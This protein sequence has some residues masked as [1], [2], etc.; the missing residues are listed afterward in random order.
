VVELGKPDAVVRKYLARMV[1]KD[2]EFLRRGG[3]APPRARTESVMPAEIV[4]T[5]PNIDFRHGNKSAEILG[6]AAFDE[7]GAPLQ[8]LEPKSRV[9]LRVSVRARQ[10]LD[11]PNVGFMLRN[12]LG[13]DFAGTNTVREGVTLPPM[14]A[15][16][17]YTVDFELDLPEL[18]PG[19]F[20]FSPAIA[21]GSLNSYEMC[22]WIDN[23]L[24]LQMAH[25]Q[26][27]IYGYIHLPCRV[28]VNTPLRARQA[29]ESSL[30]S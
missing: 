6:I 4:E 17:I 23:A 27:E 12:H 8:L 3:I 16:D 28:V 20:S 1:E 24:T 7:F 30:S 10:Y 2:A 25:A 26:G 9:T 11:S 14:S 15:G 13:M 21:N 29:A 5:I 18:Y 22:D 19:S